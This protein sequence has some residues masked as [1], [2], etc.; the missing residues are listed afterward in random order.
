MM[1]TLNSMV[2][3]PNGELKIAWD[4]FVGMLILYSVLII[5]VRLGFEIR[6]TKASSAIDAFVDLMFGL[7]MISTFFT[8]YE[9]DGKLTR[10][11]K[12][13]SSNYL[14]T[15]FFPDLLS[16]LPFDSILPIVVGGVAPD[17]LRTIKLVRVLRLFRL[18]KLFRVARLNRKMKEAKV[19]EFFH[20]ILYELVGLFTKIFMM[21][22]V[23]ACGYYFVSGCNKY[24]E[25]DDVW[26]DCGTVGRLHSRYLVAIY[27]TTTTLLSVGYGDVLLTTN[28]GRLYA[29]FV[30]FIGSITFGFIVATVGE[31][32]K[33]WDPRESA[34]KIKMEEV[35]EYITVRSF[36]KS[37][38]SQI[39]SHFDYY[40]NK[41]S[42][43]PEDVI[44]DSMPIMLQQLVLEKTRGDLST[45][46]LFRK[47]D[48]GTLS[49]V[50]HHLKPAFISPRQILVNEG[51]Y[52]VDMFFVVHGCVHG[53]IQNSKSG[54]RLVLVSINADGSDFG[55]SYALKCNSVSWA[56]YRSTVL[57]DLM[58]LSYSDIQ[59]IIKRSS[60]MLTVFEQ[61]ASEE[62]E[63]ELEI[64]K[65]VHKSEEVNSLR[66]PAFIVCDGLVISCRNA[67]RMLGEDEVR[68]KAA[69][70][71]KTMYLQG[72]D[73]E[74]KE[75]YQEDQE[76][77]QQMLNRW[78]INPFALY[79]VWFDILMMCFALI[80]AITLPYRLGFGI[81]SNIA[82]NI[83]DAITEILFAL[84]LVLAFFTAYEQSDYVLNTVHKHISRRYLKSWFI[85]DFLSTVPF[86]RLATSSTLIILK[87]LKIGKA[88]RILRIIRLARLIKFARYV[89]RD[90]GSWSS[91]FA[92]FEDSV[93][94]IVRL[95]AFMAFATHLCGCFW[96]WISLED[97][98]VTWCSNI[99]IKE[100]DYG[101]KYIAAI[102]FAYYT[103]AT[104]GYGDIPP[105]NDSER[106]F[107]VFVMVLGSTILA[108]VVGVVSSHAFNKQ[109]LK[110]LQE[111]KLNTVRDYL[112]EQGTPKSLREAVM[113]HF[114]YAIEKRTAFDELS[115]WAKLPHAYRQQ[116]I[117]V[118]HRSSF[119]KLPLF[120]KVKESIMT[121]LFECMEPSFAVRDSYV[122]NFETGSGG[123]YF[124]LRG[125]AEVVDEDEE[126]KEIIVAQIRPG[127]FFGHEKMLNMTTDFVGIRTRT[128]VSMLWLSEKNMDLLQ[129]CLPL[130]Y[131]ALTTLL[132]EA[133]KSRI[134]EPPP[135]PVRDTFARRLN[136]LGSR[137]VESISRALSVDTPEQTP[138]ESVETPPLIPSQSNIPPP[139][140]YLK[141]F[142]RQKS[143]VEEFIDWFGSDTD[144][145]TW[146]E[147]S[148]M[149]K[150]RRKSAS[151][152]PA[153]KPTN[154]LSLNSK[155]RFKAMK[156]QKSEVNRNVIEA[157]NSDG[158][159]PISHLPFL[160]KASGRSSYANLYGSSKKSEPSDDAIVVVEDNLKTESRVHTRGQV[161]IDVE[162]PVEEKKNFSTSHAVDDPFLSPSAK[163]VV[164]PFQEPSTSPL[165]TPLV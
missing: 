92:A 130:A 151:T 87:V 93:T 145:G 60:R 123:I 117:S 32:V 18:L 70:V 91:E 126:E 54:N 15:W 80:S 99:G 136:R 28:H 138:P 75:I 148:N 114:C 64:L 129:T 61:R 21:A 84:D 39:W 66:V 121:V 149:K 127:M 124:I 153:G 152:M 49:Q 58:W 98:G 45:F 11:L 34:R 108:Y 155:D 24:S 8:A 147:A 43:F 113:K 141:S 112:A 165:P 157:K 51:D 44:L 116:V 105:V 2:L 35:R 62:T 17:S 142:S 55:A 95:V 33:N 68:E 42:T 53:S 31:S 4:F 102:Y 16:T 77:T 73:A 7:D 133:I 22:H 90:M 118:V 48:Y 36:S 139:G 46:K 74:G 37:L 154:I 26:L 164:V 12:S 52:V 88:M 67:M 158:D 79:K 140:P 97:H 128:D 150:F 5:P 119:E 76:T 72:L 56:T 106:L 14:R 13:I 103:M 135:E 50:L 161:V 6:D 20:P 10:N 110:G 160:L 122:Y 29:V 82:W 3:M 38:K 1:K 78:I 85:V 30:M 131:S 146:V 63:S 19:N 134:P 125:I 86:Y 143:Q 115:L 59:E 47:E 41:L 107:A 23:L 162:A 109:G 57:T 144:E 100:E 94:R 132:Q 9:D 101:K 159:A 96:A 83:F 104:V 40:Y 120:K 137:A 156:K 65:H 81:P 111:H 71:Y 25:S 69:K 27:W 89:T 163:S